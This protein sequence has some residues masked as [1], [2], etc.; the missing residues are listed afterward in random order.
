MNNF[1]WEQQFKELYLETIKGY[2]KQELQRLNTTYTDIEIIDVYGT[3]DDFY[4]CTDVIANVTNNGYPVR[5]FNISV[6]IRSHSDYCE[7]NNVRDILFRTKLESSTLSQVD[8]MKDPWINY[9]F[10]AY[11]LNFV[12]ITNQNIVEQYKTF[13][14][15][16]VSAT[17]ICNQWHTIKDQKPTPNGKKV[18]GKW[19]PDGTGFYHIPLLT[20][21]NG[22][23]YYEGEMIDNLLKGKV[24]RKVK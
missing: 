1:D 14:K 3:N 6:N 20:L 24:I 12:Y 10:V 17:E 2:I 7:R 16:F 11:Q 23:K 9:A 21:R 13:D 19:V 4:E 18:N 15:V 5:T 22:I 8:K